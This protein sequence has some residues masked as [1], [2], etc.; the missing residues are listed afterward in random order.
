[1]TA[2]LRPTEPL[3][4]LAAAVERE[5]EALGATPSDADVLQKLLA[6]AL[7]EPLRDFLG[8]P[9][10]EF[11]ARLCERAFAIA[12][13]AQGA[14]PPELP[15]ALEALHAGSLIVDDI[16]DGSTERRGAPTLHRLVG[17]PVALN[18]GNWLYFLPQRLIAR[19]GLSGTVRLALHE[20]MAECLLSC[21][22]GQALDLTLALSRLAQGEVPVAMRA[23]G[24]R[25]T[26]ALM[27]LSAA[28]GAVAAGADPATAEALDDFGRALG[29]GLQM[30]D[31][32]S[33]V[34]NAARRDKGLEDQL[35]DRVTW[36][37]AWLAED[38]SAD[39]YA[40]L[41]RERERARDAFA[42]DAG[43]AACALLSTL[44]FR[45]GVTG[46]RRARRHLEQA[47][48]ALDERTAARS[49]R[50]ELARELRWLE[51]KF[52]EG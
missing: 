31:D 52:L 4:P 48:D 39:D 50:A 19:S 18:A 26:G 23:L 21:H 32:L 2:V 46:P 12:G 8:R 13:G 38:L 40:T 34:L 11:R 43:E 51:R 33:G 3:L 7:H 27:G 5:R 49:V 37:W 24:E 47:L 36:V 29:V 41:L 15:L 44:R 25:K 9:G 10:K 42:S 16:E 14:L 22:E 30:L 45:L 1:M 35:N 28:F 17:T 6:P 20:R